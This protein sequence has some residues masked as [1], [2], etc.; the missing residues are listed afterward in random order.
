MIKVIRSVFT[1]PGRDGDFTWMIEQPE[2]GRT[3]FVFNDNEQEFL[4]HLRGGAHRCAAGGGNA[5]IRPYQCLP[6]PR[7]AGVPTGSYE[8]GPHH[9]GYSTLDDHARLMIGRAVDHL[10]ELLRSGRFDAVAFSW[11]PTTKLGG[12]IFDTAQVVRD[13]IVEELSAVAARC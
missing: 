3:L 11:D 9:L 4:T 2:H 1:G 12:R 5:A 6:S 10:E 8:K 13:H 7:A